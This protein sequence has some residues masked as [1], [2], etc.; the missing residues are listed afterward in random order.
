MVEPL[1]MVV[2][3]LGAAPAFDPTAELTNGKLAETVTLSGVRFADES[4][5][6]VSGVGRVTG[7]D[8]QLL[9][10]CV[11]QVLGRTKWRSGGS[12]PTKTSRLFE[13]NGFAWEFRFEHDDRG[14]HGNTTPRDERLVAIT[15]W[16]LLGA[17][18]KLFGQL[19]QLELLAPREALSDAGVTAGI[20]MHLCVNVDGMVLSCGVSG[21]GT[22]SLESVSTVERQCPRTLKPVTLD[23]EPLSVCVDSVVRLREP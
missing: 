7:T 18:S 21:F 23:G 3:L 19:S 13:V 2:M 16:D 6:K 9:K 11:L 1:T 10:R 8:R 20:T 17:T 14:P 22:T 15:R 5:A 12:G 4:C